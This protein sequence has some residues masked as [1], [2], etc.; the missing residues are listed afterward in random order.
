[1]RVASPVAVYDVTIAVPPRSQGQQNVEA[2]AGVLGQR[3]VR[4]LCHHCREP[5]TP[6]PEMLPELTRVRG[7]DTGGLQ[8]YRARGCE[9]CGGTGYLGRL[10]I[11]EVLL[12]SDPLRQAVLRHDTATEVQ[13]IAS[14]D[15]METMYEDGI[16]KAVAG[17]TTMEEVIL[18]TQQE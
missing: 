10:V 7:V 13:R 14:E 9:A 18:V 16:R 3:L 11:A 8:L 1:M 5:Y 17:L 6:L 4:R 12:M 15:G 2:F